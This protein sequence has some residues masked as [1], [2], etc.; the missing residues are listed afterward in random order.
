M[1]VAISPSDCSNLYPFGVTNSW[2]ALPSEPHS[3]VGAMSY[4][5]PPLPSDDS[6][7]GMPPPPGFMPSYTIPS[8]QLSS[9]PAVDQQAPPLLSQQHGMGIK[10]TYSAPNNVSLHTSEADEQQHQIG[11]VGEKKRNKLGYHRTSVACGKLRAPSPGVCTLTHVPRPLQASEDQMHS[12]A[13]RH[14][15]T[16]Y[17][18]HS[19]EK[20]L[21]FLS[22][23][24]DLHR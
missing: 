1:A 10:G 3:M 6:E 15:G 7:M 9:L 12:F 4:H 22:S 2:E 11:S 14:T 21:Q 17:Q 16:L 13:Q 20:G 5:Y 19:V 8:Q 18:L 24:P 23:R